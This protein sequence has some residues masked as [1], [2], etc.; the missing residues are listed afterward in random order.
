MRNDGVLD[1]LHDVRRG[2][3]SISRAAE[4]DAVRAEAKRIHDELATAISKIRAAVQ[5][6]D[7]PGPVTTAPQ[8]PDRIICHS[9]GCTSTATHGPPG[10]PPIV[11]WSHAGEFPESRR[12]TVSSPKSRRR[13]SLPWSRIAM[14]EDQ[15][16]RNHGGQDLAT[17]NGRGGLD[18]WEALAVMTGQEYR[19]VAHLSEPEVFAQLE[20]LVGEKLP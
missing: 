2:L 15:A 18:F 20:A 19:D 9:E 8:H 17:L 10:Y 7:A 3:F 6:L 12:F 11:C 4:G 13:S 5:M 1:L 14:H 16:K